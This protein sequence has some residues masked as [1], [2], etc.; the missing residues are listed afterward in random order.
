M[1]KFLATTKKTRKNDQKN[2]NTIAVSIPKNRSVKWLFAILP[3]KPNEI[4]GVSSLDK[5]QVVTGRNKKIE[6]TRVSLRWKSEK[7]KLP[8]VQ[9]KNMCL[10]LKLIHFKLLELNLIT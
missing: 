2:R 8:M 6:W 1:L 5:E 3:H 9:T 10:E 4:R 7:L